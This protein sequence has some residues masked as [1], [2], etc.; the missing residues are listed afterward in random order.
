MTKRRLTPPGVPVTRLPYE[1]PAVI[2]TVQL[3]FCYEC[4]KRKCECDRRMDN[5]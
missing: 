1:K 4:K 3:G 5:A 2:K